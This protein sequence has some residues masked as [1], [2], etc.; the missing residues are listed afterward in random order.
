M[1]SKINEVEQSMLQLSS[2]WISLFLSD[3]YHVVA[4][5]PTAGAREGPD[6]VQSLVAHPSAHQAWVTRLTEELCS[7]VLWKKLTVD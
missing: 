2:A 1:L 6:C 3:E 5:V 4:A 7:S